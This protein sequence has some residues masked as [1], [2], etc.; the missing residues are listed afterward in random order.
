MKILVVSDT[1]GQTR[2]LGELLGRLAGQVELVCHLGDGYDDVFPFLSMYKGMSFLRVR[3]NCD[4]AGAGETSVITR[5]AGKTIWLSHGHRSFV[6]S[7]LERLYSDAAE[8]GADI[9]LFGHTHEYYSARENG[10]LYLNPGSL[11]FPKRSEFPTYGIIEIGET[12]EASV[13]SIRRDGLV[14]RVV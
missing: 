5:L 10:V 14:Y 2:L 11:S 12:A 1:H 4:Y 6:K 7:G 13:M 9:C 3:G 8:L